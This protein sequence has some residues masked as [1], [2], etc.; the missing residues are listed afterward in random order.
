VGNMWW[1]NDSKGTGRTIQQTMTELK[2]QGLTLIR[3]PI[4]P[5]TLEANHPQG[6]DPNLKNHPS[7][8]QTSAR[9]Q[10][11]DFIKLADQ[12]GLHVFID[13]HSC[14][15]YVGWR[16]GRLDARPPYVDNSR[17]GYDFL[18]EDYS[19]A[20]TGNPSTVKHVHAYGK[21]K[22]LEN[23]REIASLP[24]KLGVDN[25][26]GIDIFNEPYDYTWEE[27]K[28]LS[29][30]AYQ[31]ISSVNPN[32]LTIV[33]GVSGSA[34]S[35]TG[36][37][38]DKVDVPHG[39]LETNPNWGE[40]LYE[41]GEN[42]I[43]IPKDRMLFSPHIYG[44]AVFVQ[45]QYMDPTQ[46]E[47]EGLE[48]D[49]AGHAKCRV[50]IDQERVEAGWEEHFGYLR[51]LGYGMIIGEFG[52]NMDWPKKASRAD[53]ETWSHITT[54][55]DQQWQQAAVKYMKKRG[56][57]ACYWGLNP[58]SSDTLGWYLTPWDPISASNRWGE[59]TGFDPRRTQLLHDLWGM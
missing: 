5:Q 9:Q 54:N 43:N 21:E 52:G 38:A 2:E 50:V 51:D 19:C 10:L 7:V 47:C 24:E 12:N 8:R 44:P 37:P 27:W 15:N 1:V 18:R 46:P 36:N 29:E 57:Q 22:W 40:N 53:Q 4:A 30:A 6:M 11:E 48:G 3:L 26:V 17:V 33:E 35:Q 59:W 20:A 13:I 34:N 45:K 16:A 31:A 25:I 41:A 55:V 32:L 23:L 14:S 42:P 58:E 28:S 39:S 56:I 49:E